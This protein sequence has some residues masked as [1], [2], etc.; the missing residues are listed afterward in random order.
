MPNRFS[1][2]GGGAD[3]GQ[4]GS[5]PPVCE[6]VEVR[7]WMEREERSAG[8]TNHTSSRVRAIRARVRHFS[9]FAFTPS[10]LCGK[11]QWITALGMKTFALFLHLFA[12]FSFSSPWCREGRRAEREGKVKAFTPK[13][14][15]PNVL[16]NSRLWR[17]GEGV[18]TKNEKRLRRV[19]V[20]AYVCARVRACA[21]RQRASPTGERGERKKGGGRVREWRTFGRKLGSFQKE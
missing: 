17:T 7:A 18:K 12:V 4:A 6:A 20:G 10:P 11:L 16:E 5:K 15:T 8:W 14:F 3:F 19:R 9:I 21:K 13:A 1:P 2:V